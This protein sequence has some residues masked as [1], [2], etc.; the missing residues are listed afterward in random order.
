MV[1]CPNCGKEVSLDF[2]LCP[3]CGQTLQI[4][5]GQ[6]LTTPVASPASGIPDKELTIAYALTVQKPVAAFVLTGTAAVEIFLLGGVLTSGKGVW[7]GVVAF[8]YF[9]SGVLLFIAAMMMFLTG[10]SVRSWGAAIMVLGGLPLVTLLVF[11]MRVGFLS[12]GS[13]A[14]VL[15]FMM[16]PEMVAVIGGLVAIRWKAS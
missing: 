1:S 10:S 7:T 16:L 9:L 2:A 5:E 6:V 14:V 13:S 3:F 4:N 11:L 8:V 12:I 15:F